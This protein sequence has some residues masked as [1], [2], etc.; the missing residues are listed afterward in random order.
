MLLVAVFYVA[1]I[2]VATMLAFAWDKVCARNG[3]RRVPENTLLTLALVGG[4]AGA[5]MGQQIMRH[6]TRKQP[7]RTYLYTIMGLQILALAA[8][9][10]QPVR[11]AALTAIQKLTG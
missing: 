4:T 10:L 2:T 9:S 5:I 1:G 11:E 8:L 3:W 6:K 7:F